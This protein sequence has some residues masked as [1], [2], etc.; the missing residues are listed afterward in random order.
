MGL[1]KAQL[2]QDGPLRRARGHKHLCA[3]MPRKL[4]GGHPTPPSQRGSAP[5]RRAAERRDRTARAA[6]RTRPHR[7]GPGERRSLR[8]PRSARRSVTPT[9][10]TPRTTPSP[11]LQRPGPPPPGPARDDAAP[12]RP[13]LAMPGY[14]PSAITTSRSSAPRVCRHVPVPARAA[15][16]HWDRPRAK[17][18]P[19]R[20]SCRRQ[21]ATRRPPP[22]PPKR[23]RSGCVSSVAECAAFAQC[24]LGLARGECL[25]E[26]LE[27]LLVWWYR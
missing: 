11:D 7:G 3:Q 16:S 12:F 5:A 22:E 6:S 23:H 1:I 18:R 26:V 17:G 2:A 21:G 27:G 4:H 14:M 9:G 24:Q 25:R 10:P 8:H 19:E 15:R 13:T 20:L